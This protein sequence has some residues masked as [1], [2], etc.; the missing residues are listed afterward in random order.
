MILR[1]TEA[2]KPHEADSP[3]SSDPH[4]KGAVDLL[5]SHKA[6]FGALVSAVDWKLSFAP[7]IFPRTQSSLR[8]CL[9]PVYQTS[10]RALE[11]V[12]RDPD[13]G[14]TA[15]ELVPVVQSASRAG[16]NGRSSL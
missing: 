15:D 13:V 6:G 12:A 2:L 7:L 3:H 16:R 4:V 14:Y 10:S 8:I 1:I 5:F 9:H 11:A